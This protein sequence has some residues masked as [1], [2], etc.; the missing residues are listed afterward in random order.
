MKSKNPQDNEET[1]G[2]PLEVIERSRALHREGP[3]TALTEHREKILQ[4]IRQRRN[5]PRRI[6]LWISTAAACLALAIYLWPETGSKNDWMAEVPE[7]A[8]WEEVLNEEESIY[9][10]IQEE[11]PSYDY[12]WQKIEL[13]SREIDQLFT[14][15]S[16]EL[17]ENEIF[18]L[19]KH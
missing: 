12:E 3:G 13:D 19:H 10:W 16:H 7:E 15:W 11:D 14:S 1:F 8:L 5:R 2:L 17:N 6:A 9:A 4:Q 18:E